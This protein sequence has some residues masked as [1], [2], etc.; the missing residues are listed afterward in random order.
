MADK[1][2]V[3]IVNDQKPINDLWQQIINLTP[4]M[5]CVA[6][7]R[8]GKE[9]V[10]MALSLEPDVVV[11]DMMM[12]AMDGAEATEHILKELPKTLVII[13]SAYNGMEDRAYSSGAVAYLLMPI[14]PERLRD[15]IRRT[16]QEHHHA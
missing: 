11:M 9:A 1:I 5:T 2:R 7:A 15:A 16:Y 10:E 13:Y 6:S 4:D 8:D 14:P 3:L 12:P